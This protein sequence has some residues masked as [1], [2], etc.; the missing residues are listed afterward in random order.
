MI[1]SAETKRSTS[2]LGWL[3]SS[4]NCISTHNLHLLHNTYTTTILRPSVRDYPGKLLPEQTLI[5]PPSWSSSN[6]YQLLP[7]TTIHSILPVQIT[8]LAIFFAQPLSTSS[9]V[10]LLAWSPPPHIPYISS[11]NQCLVLSLMTSNCARYMQH[12]MHVKIWIKLP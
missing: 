9:L 3:S 2:V 5:H 10:Y 6:L 7:S 1:F 11:P 4:G 12:S 8:C